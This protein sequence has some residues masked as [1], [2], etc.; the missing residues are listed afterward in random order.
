M[1]TLEHVTKEYGNKTA[2]S[3]VSLTFPDKGLVIVCGESG[4][5]KTTLLNIA[6]GADQ[7]SFGKVFWCGCEINASNVEQFRRGK[8]SDVYQ[9]F[10]LVDEMSCA[11]NILLAAEAC[12]KSLSDQDVSGLLA[13]VGLN[14]GFSSKRV[15][16]LS[17]G[18]KQRVAVARA[19]VKDGAIIFADE[20]TGNLDRKNGET[21]MSL[22]RE[23]ADERLVVVVSHNER[24]NR[25]YGQYSVV[26]EDGCVISSD[27]PELPSAADEQ[28]KPFEAKPARLTPKTVI[29][30]ARTGYRK[31]TVKSVLAAISF[32]FVF[33]LSAIIN[34]LFIADIPFALASS[35][36]AAAA[37]NVLVR[38]PSN[39]DGDPDEFLALRD[40]ASP[41]VG[42]SAPL[43]S[44]GYAESPALSSLGNAIV[45]DPEVGADV[46][47]VCG[48]FPSSPDEIMISLYAAE[49]FLDSLCY[50]DVD[51]VDSLVGKTFSKTSPEIEYRICGVFDSRV[52]HVD[53]MSSAVF[54][55]E[56]FARRNALYTD[57]GIAVLLQSTIDGASANVNIF[58]F[59]IYAS[60]SDGVAVPGFDEVVLGSR[61]AQTLSLS[62]GDVFTLALSPDSSAVSSGTISSGGVASDA[63]E[64]TVAAVLSETNDPSLD[65]GLFLS[66][67]RFFERLPF[68]EPKTS[69]S[70]YFNFADVGSTYAALL[71]LEDDLSSVF[72]FEPSA[73]GALFNTVFLQNLSELYNCYFNLIQAKY[74]AFLPA[75]IVF[76]VGLICLDAAFFLFLLSS[77]EKMFDALRAL[78]YDRRRMFAVMVAQLSVLAVA[79]VALGLTV[80]GVVCLLISSSLAT[81]PLCNEYIIPL[82][83]H[84]GLITSVVTVATMLAAVAVKVKN[85]YSSTI[86]FRKSH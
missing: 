11:E 30:L 50:S 34:T 40:D 48:D 13:R 70:F 55:D 76:L 28:Q 59:D 46:D 10:M 79:I 38:L 17:G 51:A 58:G 32:I 27:L 82:G 9:D 7:P 63:V 2:L 37:K 73:E 8:V 26:L 54:V 45:Y 24:L 1:L 19:L 77:K 29:G 33:A 66:E 62:V 57:G 20:P 43:S 14:S 42:W 15:S 52:P 72:V 36:D 83:W 53:F 41:V 65:S 4:C 69:R 84:A 3:D 21:I 35:L 23:I 18:E 5:G 60:Y 6:S 44:L 39:R 85:M 56:G 81:T 25:E 71:S 31:N 78:G 86:A 75:A 12:G 67:D 47:V 61:A 80:S 74:I 64:F 68:A 49:V 16:L 22:L